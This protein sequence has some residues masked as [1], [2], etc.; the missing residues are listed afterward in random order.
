[1]TIERNKGSIKYYENE[2]LL[3]EIDFPSFDKNTII[4]THTFVDES[5]KGQ[6]I[7]KKLVEEVIEYAK[8]NNLHIKASC[9]FAIHYFSKNEC[10]LYIK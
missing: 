8:K 1:M 7:G 3:A 10:P 9:S 5:L 6:G 4:I 2:K